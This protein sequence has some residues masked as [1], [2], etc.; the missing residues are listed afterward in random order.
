LVRLFCKSGI[1]GLAI[2]WLLFKVVPFK[3]L[4]SV[5]VELAE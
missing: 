4:Y 3:W 5:K 1:C 2:L